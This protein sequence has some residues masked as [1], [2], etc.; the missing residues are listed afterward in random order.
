MDPGC[1]SM[2]LQPLAKL[3]GAAPEFLKTID[4]IPAVAASGAAVLISGETGTG[5]ELVAHAIHYLSAQAEYPFVAVNCGALADTLLEDELFGHERGAFTSADSRREGLMAQAAKGTLFLDEVDTLAPK[6][7]V[8]LLRVLQDQKY[9][10]IGSNREREAN[11]RIVAATNVP[12]DQLLQS[13][14]FRSDLYYRLCVFTLP[15]VPLRCRKQDIPA[16]AAHFLIKH[17]PKWKAGITFS[18]PAMEALLAWDWPG[19][20]RELENAVVRSIHL[21]QGDQIEVGDLGLC[22]RGPAQPSIPTAELTSFR[23]MKQ[24]SIAAFEKNYLICLMAE[25][26]GNV[27]QAALTARKERRDLGKL[28]KKYKLD[29]KSFRTHLQLWEA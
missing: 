9:R 27:S 25:H 14:K 8:D 29:P 3:I 17:S 12:L 28:L 19:N 21:S 20:V 1:R 11:A 15:L 26:S 24:A 22:P 13:G 5:K 6:A 23:A 2:R 4:L 16:L 10:M 18:S 7:Q